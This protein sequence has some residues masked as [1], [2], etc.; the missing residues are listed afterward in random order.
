[1]KKIL[2]RT[3]PAP[4]LCR[5]RSFFQFSYCADP[6]QCS[7]QFWILSISY[8]FW[9][10]WCGGDST[11][12]WTGKLNSRSYESNDSNLITFR[13]Y[14]IALR[15][16][17][18]YNAL[19]IILIMIFQNPWPQMALAKN[20]KLGNIFGVKAMFNSTAHVD[21]NWRRVDFNWNLDI[22]NYLNPVLIAIC[23]LIF[24]HTAKSI[25]SIEV[26][27]FIGA[28]FQMYF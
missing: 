27:K 6:E 28:P 8:R 12:N 13:N 17:S 11:K 10:S 7:L 14:A 1:M 20:S 26:R 22:E 25:L 2:S 5:F 23:Y 24:S 9:L 15:F 19:H 18:L 21:K 16:L 4:N 3:V